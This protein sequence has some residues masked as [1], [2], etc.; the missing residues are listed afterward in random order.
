MKMYA[1]FAY[2]IDYWFKYIFQGYDP[3]IKWYGG[4][5]ID[6]K[7]S[8]VLSD[9]ITHR[10]IRGRPIASCQILLYYK[11][12]WTNGWILNVPNLTNYRGFIENNGEIVPE[13]VLYK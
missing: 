7:L 13:W 11:E 9:Q 6:T 4:Q 1:D 12:P 8:S 3:V 5:Y 10:V 2:L